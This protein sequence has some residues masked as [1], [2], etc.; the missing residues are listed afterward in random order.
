MLDCL[1]KE[2]RTGGGGGGGGGDSSSDEDDDIPPIRFER[3][4]A[5]E[6]SEKTRKAR[7]NSGYRSAGAKAKCAG[8]AGWMC[9]RW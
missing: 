9:I 5:G 8:S 4:D 3:A 7:A 6:S 2:S 1:W